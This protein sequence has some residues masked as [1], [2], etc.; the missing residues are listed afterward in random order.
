MLAHVYPITPSAGP[1]KSSKS[2]RG[3]VGGR[4]AAGA[5]TVSD[6]RFPPADSKGS[7]SEKRVQQHKTFSSITVWQQFWLLLAVEGLHLPAFTGMLFRCS[8]SGNSFWRLD[9]YY[10][11]LVSSRFRKQR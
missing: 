9:G 5:A 11:E 2:G 8:G 4:S 10:V 1:K 3:S 6:L 7:A